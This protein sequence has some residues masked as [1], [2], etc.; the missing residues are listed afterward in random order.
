MNALLIVDMQKQW[1]RPDKVMYPSTV[2][3]IQNIQKLK[4]YFEQKN[5]PVFHIFISHRADG[6]D[7]RAGEEIFNVA[8][9][10]PTEIIEELKPISSNLLIPKTRLS[11]FYGTDLLTKLKKYRVQGVAVTGLELRACVMAT[12]IDAYQNDFRPSAIISDAVLNGNENY[13]KNFLQT[14]Q[15]EDFLKTTSEWIQAN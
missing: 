9:T 13:I 1:I 5:Q 12:Y 10:E 3:A 14:F 8:G 4:A 6:S 15:G 11:G 7:K 2:Q